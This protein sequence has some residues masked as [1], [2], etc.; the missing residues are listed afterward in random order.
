MKASRQCKT[1][2]DLSACIRE[3][4]GMSMTV[5][6]TGWFHWCKWTMA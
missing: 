3:V 1:R 5:N 6:W 4:E 2:I